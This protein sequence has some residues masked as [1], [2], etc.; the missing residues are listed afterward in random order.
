MKKYLSILCLVLLIVPCILAIC[1]CTNEPRVHV[2]TANELAEAITNAKENTVIVLDNDIEVTAQVNITQ[3]MTLDLNGNKLYNTSDIW[4]E[5]TKSW[6]IIS[7]GANGNLTITGNGE[8]S[9]KEDDCFAVDIRDGGN[10]VIKDSKFFGN[11]TCVYVF[12]GSLEVMGGEYKIQQLANYQN[13]QYRETLNCYNQNAENNTASIVVTGGSF[14]NFNPQNNNADGT[15][16]N[17]LADGYSSNQNQDGYYEV[18]K[19]I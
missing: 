5:E 13:D 7:V 15:G 19:N 3:K 4:D 11:I 2:K 9:A 14:Y 6:S 8:V 18:T 16:T 1:A 12:E 17:Y 10:C